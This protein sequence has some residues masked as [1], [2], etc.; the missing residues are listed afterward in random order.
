[1][2]LRG[3][4]ACGFAAGYQSVRRFVRKLETNSSLEARVY[5]NASEKGG[6]YSA[7]SLLKKIAR[8]DAL[9]T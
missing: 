7:H 5:L 6:K 3:A 8:A 1:M 2:V 4:N 9:P